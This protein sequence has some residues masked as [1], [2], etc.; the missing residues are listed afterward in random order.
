MRAPSGELQLAYAD[1]LIVFC[2]ER[3]AAYRYPREVRLVEGCR[4]GTAGVRTEV[5]RFPGMIHGF[6]D[7]G[8]V[9]PGAQ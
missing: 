6:F 8:P 4:R 9:S 1:E 5:R 3:L 7:M 2:R